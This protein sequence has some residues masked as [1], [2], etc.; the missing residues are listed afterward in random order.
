MHM[1]GLDRTAQRLALGQQ[2][3]LADDLAELARPHALGER[4]EPVGLG[5]QAGTGRGG[6]SA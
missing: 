4:L 1:A 3:R 6:F 5:K 2:P